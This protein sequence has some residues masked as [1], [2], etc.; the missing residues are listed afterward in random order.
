VDSTIDPRPE[1]ADPD[2]AAAVR[3]LHG[4][5][6]WALAAITS[7]IAFV[8]AEGG[9]ASAQ[10][11]GTPAPPWFLGVAGAFGVLAVVC[12]V[13]AAVCS[14]RLRRTPPAVREQAAR[15]AAGLQQGRRAHHF[16]PR[17]VVTWTLRWIGMLLILFVGV[18]SVPAV[19]DG[20]A[21]LAGAG[22]TVTFD[23]IS[24]QT[25]CSQYSCDTTT[26][27]ILETGGAGVSAT[28][29]NVV[30]LGRPFQ[31]REPVWRWGLGLALID[32][33]GTAALAI[34]LCLLMEAFGVVVL[35]WLVRLARNWRRHR[36]Q[37]AIPVTAA[38]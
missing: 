36:K 28:W 26:V 12:I 9:A 34:G 23:P 17:H 27:G 24:H 3:L 7:S 13:V 8:L 1:V 15:V 19:V 21:Y 37:T 32:S 29:Q 35:V 18:I 20:T 31:V 25:D 11:D 38:G 10:S 4:R 33:D 22:R 30:P 16:P 14:T 6:G 5:H 2:V